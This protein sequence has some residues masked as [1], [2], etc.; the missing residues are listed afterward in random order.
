MDVLSFNPQQSC[1]PILPTERMQ[2]L[3]NVAPQGDPGAIGTILRCW[4]N[5]D[6]TPDD[7]QEQ[8]SIL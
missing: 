8:T 4:D 7:G 5:D 6:C 2:A 1:V 3:A